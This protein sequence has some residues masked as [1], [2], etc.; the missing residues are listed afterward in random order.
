MATTTIEITD[1]RQDKAKVI[2]DVWRRL[3]FERTDWLN[4][5]QE[6]RRYLTAHSTADTEVGQTLPWK[7]KTTIPKLT[8]I[9]EN[10]QAYY[11]AALIPHDEWFRW[12]GRDEESHQKAN[13]IEEYMRT[14]VRMGK[15]RNALEKMVTD[16]IVYGNCFGGITWEH[17]TTISNI[18]GEEITNYVGPKLFR[19]SPLDCVIDKRAPSFEKSP[20]IR[21]KFIPISELL[22]HNEV[23]DFKYDESSLEQLRDYRSGAREDW[24]E[25][26]KEQGYEI[27]G[28]QSYTDY[29]DS[30]YV[31]I[32]EYWGDIFVKETGEVER[33]RVVVVAERSFVLLD[34]E[35]PSWNGKKPFVHAGW[36]VLPDNL[37][38]QGPLDNLVGMQYRCDH[39]ENL[40]ADTF[41]QIVHPVIKIRGDEVEPFEWGPGAKIYVGTDGDAEVMRPD[42]TVLQANTEIAIYHGMMEQMSG[43][44]REMM[45]FRTPGEK[46]AFEVDV[47]Q[48]GANRMFQDKLNRFEEYV[49]G[50]SLSIMFEMIVRNLD[51]EDVA[52][53]FN[54]DTQALTL[55][56]LTKED[57]VADGV[58]HPMGAKYFSDRMRRAQELQNFMTILQNEKTAPHV[59]GLSAAKAIENELGFEKYNMVQEN[60]GIMEQ[61]NTQQLIQQ[62]QQMMQ[63]GA[64]QEEEVTDEAIR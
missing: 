23:S 42:A 17:N 8:Q 20:F 35:N 11:M 57:V 30:Q 54:D 13:L 9:K 44:P 51:I 48:Q 22:Q 37:Y 19:I 24:T 39:L 58:L 40:K 5:T 6:V 41:D 55:T 59:S 64:P 14:K 27:D 31:E 45:G 33:N 2:D 36:R 61:M 60:V 50:P 28:F 7:N 46:T 56:E 32:L 38:G 52:R 12:E 25:F 16:W 43:S 34:M 62:F 4:K 53:T 63:A 49:I 1:P 18:T 15:Y 3:S 21:R 26:F 47:L 10:L 29:F